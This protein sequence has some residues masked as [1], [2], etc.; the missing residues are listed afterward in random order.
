MAEQQY[1]NHVRYYPA[2]H[3]VYYPLVLI[4]LIFCI[5][6]YLSAAGGNNEWLMM[7]ALTFLLGFLSFMVRQHYAL[8]NQN[9]TVRLEMRLRYYQLTQ[10][11]F[12]QFEQQL[13]FNQVAALRFAGDEELIPLLN[14]TLTEKLQP[15]SIKKLI[16]DWQPDHMRV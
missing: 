12:V 13:S 9:R 4:A 6:N 14:K 3:F 11:R 15:A 16:T 2:H 5:K 1:K 8:I 7:A 10:Q